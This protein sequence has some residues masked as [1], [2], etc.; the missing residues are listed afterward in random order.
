M[1]ANTQRRRAR[2]GILAWPALLAML[3]ALAAGA[4]EEPRGPAEGDQEGPDTLANVHWL[5]H[6]GIKITGDKVIYVDPY[7][8]KGGEKADLILITHDHS[9]HLSPDDIAKVQGEATIIVLPASAQHHLTGHI[10]LVKPGDEVTVAGIKIRA[11]PA[12]NLKKKYHP[13]DRNNVG[14]VFTTGGV[15]YYHAGDTDLIPEMASIKADVAFLPVGGT[16]TMDADEAAQ[17]A[18]VIKPKVAVPIH[19]GTIVGSRQDAEAFQKKASCE[20][21]IM[22]AE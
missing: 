7:K 10:Q 20:V 8:I 18:A 12:Y 16:Y 3:A 14:Y 13:R 17:A 1:Y 2:P 4:Q 5:G 21:R 11:V 6:A 9:D 19:W 22:T 15:T